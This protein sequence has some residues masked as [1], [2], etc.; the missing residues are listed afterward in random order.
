L[1]ADGVPPTLTE[2]DR[3]TAFSALQRVSINQQRLVDSTE[4]KLGVLALAVVGFFVALAVDQTSDAHWQQYEVIAL[5]ADTALI[6]AGLLGFKHREPFDVLI[7]V[8]GYKAQAP[9]TVD[10]TIDAMALRYVLNE[11]LR[12]I[13]DRILVCATLAAAAIVTFDLCRRYGLE[14]LVSTLWR[15]AS[16]SPRFS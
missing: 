7:F 13:K 14:A 10:R 2:I 4:A 9:Q 15:I 3:E 1:P 16:P 12:T 8:R 5:G 11:K 6:M